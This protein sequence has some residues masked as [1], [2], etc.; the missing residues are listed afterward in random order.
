M[1]LG[2]GLLREEILRAVRSAGFRHVA[3]D[4]DAD[5]DADGDAEAGD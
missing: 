3:V 4:L 5:E 2:A 1:T